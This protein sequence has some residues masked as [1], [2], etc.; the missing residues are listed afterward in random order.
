[1]REVD[2]E[3][4]YRQGKGISQGLVSEDYGQLS[5]STKGNFLERGEL[6]CQKGTS[7]LACR[8]V[9]LICVFVR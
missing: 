4:R 9:L 5:V 1:M 8:G 3:E 6:T 7:P 2:E